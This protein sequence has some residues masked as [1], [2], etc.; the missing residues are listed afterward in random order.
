MRRWTWFMASDYEGEWITT[1]GNADVS[2]SRRTL[3]AVLRYGDETKAYQRIEA[4][5]KEGNAISATVTPCDREP[6]TYELMGRLFE[7]VVKNGAI[8]RTILLT[9]G[10]TVIGLAYGPRSSEVSHGGEGPG[11]PLKYAL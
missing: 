5:I 6:R 11:H 8:T 3:K 4:K 2:E 10:T 7:G 1:Q 9:D